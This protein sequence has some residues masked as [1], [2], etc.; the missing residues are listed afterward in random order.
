MKEVTC[1]NCGEYFYWQ[2]EEPECPGCGKRLRV[3]VKKERTLIDVSS[4]VGGRP[5]LDWVIPSLALVVALFAAGLA[6]K[7]EAAHPELTTFGT[8]PADLIAFPEIEVL[9]R[10]TGQE[11]QDSLPE[12]V[13]N[14]VSGTASPEEEA[15]FEDI[16]IREEGGLAG[17]SA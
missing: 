1:P 5:V 13:K 12:L 3:A 7:S 8:I 16:L 10:P 14:L 15:E 17:A 9:L 11:L 6:F 4:R 2:P